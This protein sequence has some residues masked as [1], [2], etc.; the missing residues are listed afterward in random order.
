[1]KRCAALIFLPGFLSACSPEFDSQ[2][3]VSKFRI[4]AVTAQPPE[5]LPGDLV[6][7]RPLLSE[8]NSGRYPV[9][10]WLACI[11]YPDQTASQCLE[12]GGATVTGFAETL[13]FTLPL[14]ADGEGRQDIYVVL[15]ACVGTL[16]IPDFARGDYDFCDSPESDMATR[17][18]G[19]VAENPNRNPVIDNIAF[20]Y[21]GSTA[22]NF[23]PNSGLGI[24]CKGAC[25]DIG[26][27]VTLRPGSCET[28]EE[29]R[30]SETLIRNENLFVSWFA[31]TGEFD[32]SRTYE[33]SCTDPDRP[34]EE[35]EALT[36][37]AVWTPPGKSGKVTFYFVVYDQRG[38]V[39]FWT[40]EG[41]IQVEE[42]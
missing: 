42:E 20:R 34:E 8:S 9:L 40:T 35:R 15:L 1:M 4:I 41:Y 16:R 22:V 17:K 30:F 5:G 29:T 2:S 27:T 11:P 24:F 23:N 10:L 31:T 33:S 19:V 37:D 26:V 32:R 39:D 7:L 21:G 6:T 25:E 14:L 18:I 3:L 13:S 36:F 28:F 38:G 12:G